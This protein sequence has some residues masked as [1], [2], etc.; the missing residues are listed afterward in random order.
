[1]SLIDDIIVAAVGGAAAPAGA[2][3]GAQ[4]TMR[5]ST[6]DGRSAEVIS[7]TNWA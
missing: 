7:A 6:T 4:A 2:V 5:A 1:M 3:I